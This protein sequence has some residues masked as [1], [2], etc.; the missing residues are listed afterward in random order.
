M[1]LENLD[2]I[3]ADGR[4]IDVKTTSVDVL[5]KTLEKV[6]QERVAKIQDIANIVEQAKQQ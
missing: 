3:F 1:K 6:R 5:E 2:G 4:I